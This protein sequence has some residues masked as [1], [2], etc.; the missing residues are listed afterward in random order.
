MSEQIYKI[1][2]CVKLMSE[3]PDNY[4]DLVV[5]SPP[6]DNLRTY[7]GYTFDF[8]A[9]AKELFRILK[10]GGVVV[11]IV[12]DS[13]KDGNESGTSFRQALFFKEIG[14]NLF[15]TMIYYKDSGL[16]TGALSAY[17]Q[18]FEYM[19]ILSKG[20]PKTIN[21]IRDRLNKETSV[22]KFIKNKKQR[23]GSY[24]KQT[25]NVDKFGIRH[26]IWIVGNGYNKSTT[27]DYAFEHP[28]IFPEQLAKDHI[29]SWSNVGDIILDPFL[30]SGTTLKMCQL[31]NRNGIGFELKQEYE[32]I[33]IKRLKLDNSK[34]TDTWDCRTMIKDA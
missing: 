22:G 32:S 5:T 14:L 2:D 23:D 12:G 28:A 3:L 13:T 20:K 21:L 1:G 6:Y 29:I 4:I 8:E 26:N 11:W 19:F 30:G 10:N 18:K 17:L 27:D 24:K 16:N 33:I 34:L 25:I 9:T 15:D 7:G 31:L